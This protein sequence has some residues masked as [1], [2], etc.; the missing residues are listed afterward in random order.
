MPVRL[1]NSLVFKWPDRRQVDAAARAWANSAVESHRGVLR[2]GY[3][4]S[5]ARGDWGVG[6]DLDIIAIVDQNPEPFE[7]RP[8]D[9]DLSALPV[10]ADLLVYTDA[11][12]HRLQSQGGRFARH[13]ERDSVWVYVRDQQKQVG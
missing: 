12:W 13:L 8:L 11:E 9:W 2:I 5:C 3:F 1:L 6:S 4:G 7:R 10:P